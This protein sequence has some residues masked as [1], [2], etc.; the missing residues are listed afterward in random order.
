[1]SWNVSKKALAALLLSLVVPAAHAITLRCDGCSHQQAENRARLAGYG[2]HLVMD[3]RHGVLWQFSVRLD[4][5]PGRRR[6]L[7]VDE[8]EPSAADRASFLEIAALWNANGGSLK[9]D[10][11]LRPGDPLYPTASFTGF[12]ARDI[13]WTTS[14]RESIGRTVASLEFSGAAG[15]FVSMIQSTVLHAAEMVAGES[16]LRVIVQFPD[17]STAVFVV[18][19]DHSRQAQYE[20]GSARDSEGNIVPDQSHVAGQENHLDLL[21]LYRFDDP[22]N[23]AEWIERAQLIGIPVV[24]RRGSTGERRPIVVECVTETSGRLNCVARYG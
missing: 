2:D 13:T 17:R 5:E 22:D 14:I 11:D 12:G 1:M 20:L 16:R 10:Y 21:G 6:E 23:F 19:K 8:I 7:R 18:D 24:D 15:R 4:S 3:F 9:L